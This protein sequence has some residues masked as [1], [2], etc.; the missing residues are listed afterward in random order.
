MDSKDNKVYM[1]RLNPHSVDKKRNKLVPTKQRILGPHPR[2][3]F[4]AVFVNQWNNRRWAKCNCPTLRCPWPKHE[5]D[6]VNTYFKLL[7]LVKT[8][9]K[10]DKVWISFIEGLHRHAAI[11]A[12]LLC[13]KFDYSK[14]IIIQGSLQLDDFEKAQIPHYK[15]PGVTLRQQ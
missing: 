7:L 3:E 11:F 8:N 13:I 1:N 6:H 9:I 4:Q 15:N 10:N 12:S 2:G 5:G 14:N